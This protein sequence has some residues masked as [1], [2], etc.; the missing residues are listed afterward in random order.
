MALVVS[1]E[2]LV[3]P[4][5][6][7]SAGLLAHLDLRGTRGILERMGPRAPMDHQALLEPPGREELWVFLV[8]E[9]SEA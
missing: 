4:D 7:G 8:K 6:K 5:G 1:V 9:E 3:H 2:T